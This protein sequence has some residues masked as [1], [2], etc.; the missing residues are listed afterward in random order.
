MSASEGKPVLHYLDIGSL[1][2]GEV[3]RLFLKDAGI[4]FEDTR[5][6]FNDSW[7][8]TKAELQKKG[9]SRTGKVPV[10]EYKGIYLSQHIPILRYLARELKAYDGATSLEKHLVD[11]V[12]DLY[13]DWRAQWVANLEKL[14]DSY[15]N[16]ILPDHYKTLAYY[17]GK[18][19]G[20]FL[21]GDRVTYADFAVFQ[22]IDNNEKIG[23]D[24]TLPE[25][26]LKF[27]TAFEARPRVAAYLKSGRNTKA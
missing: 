2:R 17:Y 21:L 22:S 11:V 10:L 16:E 27:K 26:L 12:A 8:D 6:P 9:I 14:S 1:G 25:E 3:I 13:I 24:A 19:G 7:K 5:Y 23:A 20:P 4:D 18:N 15:K